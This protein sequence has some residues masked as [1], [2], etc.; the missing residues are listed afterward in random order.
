MKFSAVLILGGGKHSKSFLPAK[1]QSL[2]KYAI[3]DALTGVAKCPAAN[4]LGEDNKMMGVELTCYK[5]K[6][7]KK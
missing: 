6:K 2:G 7:L 3:Y 4:F 5:E 1:L